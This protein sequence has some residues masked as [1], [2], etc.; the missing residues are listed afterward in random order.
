M[1]PHSIS[2]IAKK[3][4]ME[5]AIS[6]RGREIIERLVASA[7]Q[8]LSLA[9][10]SKADSFAKRHSGIYCFLELGPVTHIQNFNVNLFA[11]R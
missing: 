3:E 2:W 1:V 9:F 11:L 5:F 4:R 7:I 6:S 10:V 8:T